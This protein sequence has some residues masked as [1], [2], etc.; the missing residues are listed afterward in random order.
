MKRFW[1]TLWF[2]GQESFK[3][4][5]LII[6]GVILIVTVGGA[7][8]I[9]HFSGSYTD[10]V[11]VN[12]SSAYA[13]AEEV[14]ELPYVNFML[15]A[16]ADVARELLEEG[17]VDY[18]FVI[19]GEQR[20]LLRSIAY[21]EPSAE[22]K[23]FLQSVL[24]AMHI[25]DLI[26]QYEV[27]VELVRELSYPIDIEMEMLIDQEDVIAGVVLGA[28][29]SWGLYG[30]VLWIG[31]A[32]ANSVVSEKASRVMEIM[33]AKVP[34]TYTMMAKI[35]AGL[36]DVVLVFVTVLAGAIIA[37]ILG[38][39]EIRS[40]VDAL[41]EIISLEAALLAAMVFM[42]GFFIYALLFAA[43]GAIATSVESLSKILTPI[44]MAVIVPVL[45]PTFLD[46]DSIVLTI[47]SYVPL[48]SPFLIVER[49]LKGYANTIELVIIVGIM[50]VF[51]VIVLK[52][53]G[54]IYM[55]GVSHSSE[56]LTFKD[57]KKLLQK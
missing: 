54:R 19:G 27:S 32:I 46:T 18:V 37:E 1:I 25:N 29:V 23:L 33:L 5:S 17:E 50:I 34:P 36:L 38:F 2:Y 44:T 51:A 10:V 57:F 12:E 9:N 41:F 56:K 8:A 14:L 13:L 11:I 22:V 16:S 47:L 28:I 35:F 7:Y 4:N 53:A 43:A 52:M 21:T 15:E 42:L 3:R 49:Y 24:T 55:N 20:P 48:F 40:V 31:S 45:V 39:I 26:Q 30:I 6:L